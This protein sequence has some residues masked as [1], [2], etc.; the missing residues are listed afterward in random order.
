M[1][2][3]QMPR[4]ELPRCQVLRPQ[5]AFKGKQALL[6]N[7]GI[8]AQT[9]GA[10]GIHM[11]L[12][13]IPP[14]AR[15]KAHK[16]DAHE[17]AIYGLQGAPGVW[18]GENLEHHAVLRPGEFFYIPANVPHVPYNPSA[19]EEVVVVIARTD[20]NEQESVTLLPELDTIHA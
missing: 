5:D 1:K 4:S 12:V 18:H 16:H 8:S 19:T 10:K 7:V 13:T 11:Q 20:P 6:Y 15:A 17:T 9:V 2:D 3:A 14:G